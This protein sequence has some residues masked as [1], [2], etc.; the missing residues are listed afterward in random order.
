M[1]FSATRSFRPRWQ[2]QQTNQPPTQS[3]PY[4]NPTMNTR[5]EMISLALDGIENGMSERKA[6]K[7][8]GIAR[9]TLQSRRAGGST[10]YIGHHHQQRLSLEQES[11]LCSWILDQEACGYAP[12]H[13]PMREM[14]GLM[15]SIGGDS[16][17][18]GRKWV[19]AFMKR[20][21]SIAS[22]IGKPIESAR[23]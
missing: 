12:S 15:L 10:A 14:A 22:I 17:P 6:A 23:I 1:G 21:P 11:T 4:H 2:P 19:P 20:N 5:E 13:A 16:K 3:Q 7:E 9:T 18:L 8:Y